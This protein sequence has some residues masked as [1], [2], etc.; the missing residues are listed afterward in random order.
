MSVLPVSPDTIY[1]E[2]Q[3]AKAILARWEERLEKRSIPGIDAP[4]GEE[5]LLDYMR[6]LCG[7][8]QVVSNKCHGLAVILAENLV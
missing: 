5:Q 8:L 4:G 1:D 6:E 7:E 3:S 2:I